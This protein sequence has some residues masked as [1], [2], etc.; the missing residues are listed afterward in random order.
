MSLAEIP[1]LVKVDLVSVLDV[2]KSL[3]T[4]PA[5]I[6][7]VGHESHIGEAVKSR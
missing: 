4:D 1:D 2:F 7:G 5:F 3:L 6:L